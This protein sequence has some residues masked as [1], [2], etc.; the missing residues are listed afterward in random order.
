MKRAPLVLVMTVAALIYSVVQPATASAQTGVAI[1][2]VG[3][4]SGMTF[5]GILTLR[6]FVATENGLAA[7]GTVTGTA[8]TTATGTTIA[9][10][11]NVTMPAAVA[12]TTC[13]ILHLDLGP[14]FLDVLGLQVDLSQVVLDVA[15]EPGA[16]RLLGN[17]LCAVVGLLDRPAALARVLTDILGAL[18]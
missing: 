2:I 10:V 9:V 3:A 8:T 11:R 14:L 12:E 17:L 1:P 18:A 6:R 5:D 13:S 7:V 16:G 15:A 4:G